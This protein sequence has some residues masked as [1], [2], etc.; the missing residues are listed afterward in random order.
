MMMMT[1][2]M[3]SQWQN[4]NNEITNINEDLLVQQGTALSPKKKAL[5]LVGVPNNAQIHHQNEKDKEVQKL[6]ETET[7]YQTI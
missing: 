3:M 2:M 7:R 4:N 5:Q 1:M 6:H